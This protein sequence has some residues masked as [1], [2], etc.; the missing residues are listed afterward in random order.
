MYSPGFAERLEE[1][2]VFK[3]PKK[4]APLFIVMSSD[5]IGMQSERSPDFVGVNFNNATEPRNK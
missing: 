2:M 4:R 1:G 3:T 5:C